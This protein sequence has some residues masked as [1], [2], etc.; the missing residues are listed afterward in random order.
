MEIDGQYR[1][2]PTGAQVRTVGGKKEVLLPL[3]FTSGQAKVTVTYA[4]MD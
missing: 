4:W 3:A 1:V 2:R